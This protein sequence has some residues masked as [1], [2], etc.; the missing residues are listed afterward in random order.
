MGEITRKEAAAYPRIIFI[1]S[2]LYINKV[3]F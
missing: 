2:K 3:Q 1:L